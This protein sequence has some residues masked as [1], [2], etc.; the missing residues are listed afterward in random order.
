M[1]TVG[2]RGVSGC[3]APHPAPRCSRAIVR[4]TEPVLRTLDKWI[5]GSE[6]PAASSESKQQPQKGLPLRP[7]RRGGSGVLVGAGRAPFL[8]C[9]PPAPLPAGSGPSLPLTSH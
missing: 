3:P 1:G 6:T 9:K 8:G 2:G 4:R 5:R 7:A